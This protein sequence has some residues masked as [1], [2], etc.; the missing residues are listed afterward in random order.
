MTTRSPPWAPNVSV[1][2]CVAWVDSLF[3]SLYPPS[4]SCPKTPSPQTPAPITA[5][6]ATIST[7][8]RKRATHDPQPANTVSPLS[9]HLHVS[10][11]GGGFQCHSAAAVPE[12]LRRRPVQVDL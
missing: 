5:T 7:G 9:F 12:G 4:V 10:A 3:G 1:T 8:H 11:Q 2:T 6:S